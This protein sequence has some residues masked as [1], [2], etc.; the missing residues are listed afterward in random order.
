[1]RHRLAGKKLNRTA[2]HRQAMLSNMSV[3]LIRHEIIKTTL[4]RAKELRRF[5]EP[6]LSLAKHDSLHARRRVFSVLRDRHA[7]TKLFTEL[8]PLYRD[9]PGGYCRIVKCGY[10]AGDKAPLAYIELLDRIRDDKEEA[11]GKEESTQ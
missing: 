3:S 6:L 9:R 7:V 5:C 11:E 2:S 1:M 10:R 4:T 8:A